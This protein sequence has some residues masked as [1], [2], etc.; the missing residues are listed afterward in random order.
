MKTTKFLTASLLVAAAFV[1]CTKDDDE[2][3]STDKTFMLNASVSNTAEVG[4]ANLALAKATN[5][6]VRA[7]AM[8]MITEH[9]MAQTDLKSLGTSVGFAVND[10]IDPVHMQIMT[11]LSAMNGRRF[12]SAY[13]HTQV[14]DHDVTILNFQTELRSG[15][16]KEVRDYA[17]RYLPHIRQHRERADSIA[18][19][20][21]RR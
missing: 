5:P 15:Q 13:M 10:T 7:F 19:A 17:D 1:S 18:N 2:V 3:N 21:F 6:A 12:D 11:E 14:N 9:T 20:Y 16:H 8:H 4:A